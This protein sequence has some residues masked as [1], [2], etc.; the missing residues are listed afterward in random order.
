MRTSASSFLFSTLVAINC[1][2]TIAC[3][4]HH[5]S[6]NLPESCQTQ[7]A[8]QFSNFKEAQNQWYFDHQAKIPADPDQSQFIAGTNGHV[9]LIIHGF[10]SS[11]RAMEDLA[12]S[13]AERGDTVIVPLLTGFG[14]DGVTANLSTE[15]DWT[16]AFEQ[17]LKIGQACGTQVS[18]IS[19]SL[20]GAIVSDAV[21]N[22]GATGIDRLVFLAPFYKVADPKMAY[23][24]EMLS[25]HVDVIDMKMLK[26]RML[27]IDPYNWLPIPRPVPGQPDPY[28]PMKAMREVLA[29]QTLFAKDGNPPE[30]AM[31]LRSIIPV[32]LVTSLGD[33]V[34]DAEYASRYLG[35]TST[36]LTQT[37]YLAD[38]GIG[39]SLE[40]AAGN[41]NFA[42][43]MAQMKLFLN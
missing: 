3:S 20:G 22:H 21:Y 11:P 17:T 15:A 24:A 37:I 6:A 7:M 25:D 12:S 32:Y 36:Q 42:V 40:N 26:D 43:L 2:F 16:S 38:S 19:H 39:H 28:F 1:I 23:A 35:A 27:G 30:I 8:E 14:I 4:N 29:M 31:D 33:S 34:V 13:L 10:T 5:D 9:D 41:P 18:V